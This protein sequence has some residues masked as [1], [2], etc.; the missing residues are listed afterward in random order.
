MHKRNCMKCVLGEMCSAR[1]LRECV[2]Y[3]AQ[4]GEVDDDLMN[5]YIEERREE[6]HKEWTAYVSEDYE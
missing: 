5:E 4:Y 3:L 1:N 2:E 6:F